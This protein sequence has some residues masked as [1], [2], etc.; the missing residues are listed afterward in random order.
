MGAIIS[1]LVS[2]SGSLDYGSYCLDVLW[3]GPTAPADDLRA[4]LLPLAG[5]LP[6][7]AGSLLDRI[8][9]Y[10]T[11]PKTQLQLPILFRRRAEGR[12]PLIHGPVDGVNDFGQLEGLPIERARA[13]RVRAG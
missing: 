13:C 11:L 1:Q 7:R 12:H 9:G 2:G 3:R 4:H 10:R 8:L 5:E 6:P